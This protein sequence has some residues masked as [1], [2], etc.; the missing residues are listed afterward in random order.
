MFLTITPT[1]ALA[2]ATSPA[3][4]AA[5]LNPGSANRTAPKAATKVTT[6]SLASKDKNFVF[7]LSLR[8]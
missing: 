1:T 7:M 3:V 4:A 8:N 6:V 2:P 5:M